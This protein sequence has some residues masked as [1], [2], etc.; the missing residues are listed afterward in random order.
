MDLVEVD[1]GPDVHREHNDQMHMPPPGLLPLPNHNGPLVPLP[2]DSRCEPV[3][4][5]GR[6]PLGLDVVRE[7][8][9]QE[10]Q[11]LNAELFRQGL[12]F[13]DQDNRLPL[14]VGL[15]RLGLV[16]CQVLRTEPIGQADNVRPI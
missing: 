5:L 6:F 9:R 7:G 13:I 8:E 3:K 2:Q 1:P 12:N 15:Y 16:L 11:P 4:P 10:P 14:V